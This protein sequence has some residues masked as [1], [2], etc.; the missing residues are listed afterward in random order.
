[1][2]D[3]VT[4]ALIDDHPNVAPYRHDRTVT[5]DNNGTRVSVHLQGLTAL[6]P[7]SDVAGADHRRNAVFPGDNGTVAQ[8][9]SDVGH[10]PDSVGEEL[11]PGGGCHGAD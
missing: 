6:N 5:L 1:M 2:A 3:C 11:G 4:S 9:S 8:D 7:P 10:E